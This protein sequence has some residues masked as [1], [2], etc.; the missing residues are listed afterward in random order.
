MVFPPAR[1]WTG[2]QPGIRKRSIAVSGIAGATRRPLITTPGVSASLRLASRTLPRASRK[3]V[4]A[5]LVITLG[6][7]AP[8][9]S[10]P[11]RC[12]SARDIPRVTGPSARP[13]SRAHPGAGARRASAGVPTIARPTV[14]A[15]IAVARAMAPFGGSNVE[16]SA[17]ERRGVRGAITASSSVLPSTC[18]GSSSQ[19]LAR[20][21]RRGE[22]PVRAAHRAP[23]R[24]PRGPRACRSSRSRGAPL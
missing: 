4:H 2:V 10:G 7:S 16:C 1:T 22:I 17:L 23:S 15:S 20:A 19:N 3:N 13:G 6:P 21:R 5:R 24:C 11:M 8:V 12:R 18:L 9:A 14:S